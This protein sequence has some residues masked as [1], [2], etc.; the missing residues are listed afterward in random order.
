MPLRLLSLS[1]S[2]LLLLTLLSTQSVAELPPAA[3]KVYREQVRPF[4]TKHC[5]ECHGE[6][7]GKVGLTLH[8]LGSDFAAGKNADT[9]KEVIDR[10]NLGEMP[11]KEMP[12]PDAQEAFAVVQWVGQELTRM[13]RESRMSG[14]RIMLRRMNRR[15][16][17]N[18]VRDLL[19]LDANFARTLAEVL[20]AD[21][22]AEG[23]D[24]L[25]AA[26]FIDATQ[27]DAYLA[28]GRLIANEAIVAGPEP[29]GE[30]VLSEAQKA[31]RPLRDE[32]R[33]N[34]F[35]T[36]FTLPIGA[37]HYEFKPD[38]VIHIQSRYVPSR[39]GESWGRLFHNVILDDLVT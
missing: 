10:M 18:T 28:A 31:T 37:Q 19:K 3:E 6:F 14:G 36:D 27:L 2:P 15:E 35:G 22:K 39:N 12:R 13:E 11:P 4:L 20:P 23:F 24:R 25:S 26:L 33:E 9:W 16:Y 30:V 34:I 5:H 7:D 32:A 21:G 17:I 8:D 38:G 29:R 1:L